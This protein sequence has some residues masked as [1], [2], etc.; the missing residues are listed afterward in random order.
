MEFQKA[1]SVAA[2]SYGNWHLEHPGKY[3][4]FTVGAL[5]DQVYKGYGAELRY[6]NFKA[7]AQ[8][9]R[10]QVVTH[11]GENVITP[12][13]SWSDGRTRAW[14][15]VWGGAT[16]PWLVSV[17]TP[18]DNGKSLYGHGVGMSAWDAIGRANAGETYDGILR[19]YYQGTGLKSA[20]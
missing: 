17:A 7:A 2:R 19:Y 5:N 9:T 12:Y 1:L 15:E 4:H 11:N 8:A 3:D 10:G 13:F 16:K 6:P 14:T 20:Y 18:Y